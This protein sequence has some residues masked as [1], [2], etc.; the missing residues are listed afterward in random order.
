MPAFARVPK[1]PKGYANY[2]TLVCQHQIMPTLMA[3]IENQ[4]SQDDIIKAVLAP[5]YWAAY[6]TL[7]RFVGQN[8][9][10]KNYLCLEG[11]K[12]RVELPHQLIDATEILPTCPDAI[13]DKIASHARARIMA[14]HE[15]A[16]VYAVFDALDEVCESA[17]Q[18]RLLFPQVEILMEHD[19][20]LK[21][22]LV[23]FGGYRRPKH[24]PLISPALRGAIGAAKTTIAKWLL[25]KES[26]STAQPRSI[27]HLVDTPSHYERWGRIPGFTE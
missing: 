25:I 8:H 18:V 4:L 22:A 16:N 1:M 19:E 3:L 26:P 11:A 13:R 2:F 9:F 23:S 21:P 10:A 27:M 5:D 24:M 6:A 15:A 17:K 12:F 14:A 20:S 7:G